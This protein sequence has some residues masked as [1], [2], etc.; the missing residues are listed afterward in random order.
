MVQ[1]LLSRGAGTQAEKDGAL[2]SAAF[3]GSTPVVELLLANHANVNGARNL[4]GRT[5]LMA[6]VML[7]H[8]KTVQTL[9]ENGADVNAVGW[10][11]GETSL[12][13]SIIS[14]DA[15]LVASLLKKEANPN[16][17]EADG[18]RPL[19]LA[20]QWIRRMLCLTFWITAR[21]RTKKMIAV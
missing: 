6:A 17:K 14:S 2:V 1:A 9:L 16:V 15:R 5:A 18:C 10:K 4:E 13:L 7:G 12:I 19:E 3:S 20:I 21:I 11:K 8:R